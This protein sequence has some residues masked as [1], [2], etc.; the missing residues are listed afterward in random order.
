MSLDP[1]LEQRLRSGITQLGLELDTCRLMAYLALLHKWN[2]TYNLTAIRDP[3]DMLVKHLLDSLAIIPFVQG[4]RIL[5]VGT[6]AGLPGIPLAIARPDWK[7][8]LLDSNGKK[9][10]FLRAVRRE[11][12]LQNIDIVQSRVESYHPP[13]SFATVVSRAFAELAQMLSLSTHLLAEEG[14]WLAMKARVPEAELA[15]IPYMWTQHHYQ[16]PTL[17][18]E[19]CVIVINHS[20]R[21]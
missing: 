21:I 19:R 16:V 5:D 14:I 1:E 15:A 20:S 10:R 8:T 3:A 2:K 4:E 9:I 18:S 6:G 11:L 12:A 17:D 13:H 7:L